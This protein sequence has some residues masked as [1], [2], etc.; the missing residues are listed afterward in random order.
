[1]ACTVR[2]SPLL[3]SVPDLRINGGDGFDASAG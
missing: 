3:I 2:R 1:M